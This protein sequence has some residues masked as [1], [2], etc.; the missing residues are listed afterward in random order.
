MVNHA[1]LLLLAGKIVF[2]E[3]VKAAST[4]KQPKLV[5]KTKHNYSKFAE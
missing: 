1:A 2:T 5:R 3:L 4:S